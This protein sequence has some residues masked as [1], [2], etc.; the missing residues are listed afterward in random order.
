MR[1]SVSVFECVYMNVFTKCS[2]RA[3]CDSKSIFTQ[4]EISM[5]SEPS[6]S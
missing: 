2:A 4:S 3:G 5:N 1:V 6:F